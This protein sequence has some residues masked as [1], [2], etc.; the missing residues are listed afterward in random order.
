MLW[1]ARLLRTER[2]QP[3]KKNGD[4]DL[5]GHAANHRPTLNERQGLAAEVEE[6]LPSEA[7]DTCGDSEPDDSTAIFKQR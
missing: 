4:K 5:Q 6:A 7:I 2:A 1:S 3:R